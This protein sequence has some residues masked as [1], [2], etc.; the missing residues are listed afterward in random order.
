MNI[1]WENNPDG[2][3]VATL[4]SPGTVL[5]TARTDHGAAVTFYSEWIPEGGGPDG[6]IV[7]SDGYQARIIQGETAGQCH[8]GGQ[9][10]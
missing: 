8:L 9:C 1:F 10:R 7:E 2:Y 4:A 5:A 3:A 6:V